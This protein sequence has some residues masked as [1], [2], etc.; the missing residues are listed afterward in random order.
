MP[1]K[2]PNKMIP[3]QTQQHIKR[4]VNTMT[5]GIYPRNYVLFNVR[6]SLYYIILHCNSITD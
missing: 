6:K 4:R 5:K 1:A 2:I 3:N